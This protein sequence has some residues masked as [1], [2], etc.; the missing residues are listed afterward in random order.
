MSLMFKDSERKFL[1][2]VLRIMR[3]TVGTPLTLAD[4]EI[5]FTRR[6]YENI[7]GKA[8]VFVQLNSKR[9]LRS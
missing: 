8:Q 7:Q 6:N 3:D 4:I 9:V 2:L 1:K 5:K